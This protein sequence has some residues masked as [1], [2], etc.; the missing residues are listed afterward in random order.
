MEARE[1][2]VLTLAIFCLSG[3]HSATFTFTN[4]CSYPVWPGTLMGG[5]GAQLSSTGFELASSASM[6][7]DVPAPWTGRF[8][9]RTLCFTDSTGKFTC[10]TAD[11]CGSGQVACNGA[12]AIPPASLVELTLAAKWWTRFL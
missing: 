1:L 8:W 4:K 10:S 11:D 9:G 2:F 12:S 3:I 6:T 5:G 7:L